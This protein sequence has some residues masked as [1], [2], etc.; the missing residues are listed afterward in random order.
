M[1]DP[2]AAR[3]FDLCDD[4]LAVV[5]ERAGLDLSAHEEVRHG[6]PALR[7]AFRHQAA[8]R[9]WNFDVYKGGP[10]VEELLLPRMPE[11]NATQK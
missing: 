9:S 3:L 7:G 1:R 10:E 11:E 4:A 8:D 6:R 5:V 2:H